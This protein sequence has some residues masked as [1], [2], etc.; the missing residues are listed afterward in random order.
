LRRITDAKVLAM[1]QAAA[2]QMA[3]Q[4]EDALQLRALEEEHAEAERLAAAEH[5]TKE[6]N[7][8]L[9]RRRVEE[10]R[11]EVEEADLAGSSERARYYAGHVGRA[12]QRAIWNARF[13]IDD[14]VPHVDDDESD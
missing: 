1:A 3:T 14:A 6:L 8:A 11:A 12:Q 5:W 10:M 9:R 4:E 13:A 2:L 7:A